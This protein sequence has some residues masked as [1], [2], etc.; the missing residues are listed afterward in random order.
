MGVDDKTQETI[1]R[2]LSH[3]S[4]A[5][6]ERMTE[7]N[8]RITR[9]IRNARTIDYRKMDVPFVPNYRHTYDIK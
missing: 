9:A 7:L 8:E 1:S 5:E 4:I 3:K 2:M 6:A